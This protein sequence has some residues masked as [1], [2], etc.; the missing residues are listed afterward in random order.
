MI[1]RIIE[2]QIREVLF[3]GKAILL[4]GPRQSGKTT[5][6]KKIIKNFENETIIFDADDPSVENLLTRPNTLQ[7]S[8]LIGNKTIVFIDEAQRIKDIGITSKIIVD[9]FSEVQLILSGSSAF[10]L[11]QQT[12]EPLTGRKRT[13]NLYPI[14]WNEWQNHSGFVKAE[15]DLENRLVFGFYPDILNSMNDANTLL[16]ELTDSYLYKDILM[17]GN[18]KKPEDIK[19]LLQALAFQVG[20]E[21]S[22]R[23]L[24]EIVGL[25]PKTI[26]RYISILE[27]AYVVFKLNPLS[28]NLRNEIKTNRKI[29]FYDNGIRNAVI[30]QLQPISIRQD[31]GQLW[32]NFIVSERLKYLNNKQIFANTYFW[33]TSQQQEVDYIEETEGRFNAYEI[34]WNPKKQ[35]LISKT[36]TNT[37]QPDTSTTINRQNF[38]DFLTA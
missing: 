35:H 23:E 30:G 32:E 4:I 6:I 10:D 8:Q 19:K 3:K 31:I 28:R 21:V 12:N 11:T 33:R 29:Y 18:I 27:K 9:Q 37:Y 22:L 36:F 5:L 17:F 26:D 16:R 14:S 20:S 15:Q 2:N 1:D 13:F 24:G 38:K 7:I 25:D 34:K